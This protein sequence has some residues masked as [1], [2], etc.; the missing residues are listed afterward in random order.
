MG[1]CNPVHTLAERA[2]PDR[3]VVAATSIFAPASARFRPAAAG[4]VAAHA[5]SGLNGPYQLLSG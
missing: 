5:I 1:D 4:H 2:T 3:V